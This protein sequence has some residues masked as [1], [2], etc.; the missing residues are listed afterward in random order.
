M[1]DTKTWKR[2]GGA[3]GLV[4]G[5]L[6]AGG[7]LAGTVT[8]GAAEDTSGGTDSSTSAEDP[9]PGRGDEEAL[10]GDVR[11]QVEA[12]VLAAYPDADIERS[13]TDSG[14]V[15]ESHVVTADGERLT[16]LVGEDFAVTGTETGGPG[17]GGRGGPGEC[18]DDGAA[19]D[20][21]TEAP[22]EEGTTTN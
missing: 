2:Y 7:V 14:G 15:Y 10:T 6:V 11:T 9:R 8:A 13:E 21:S 4:A 12:A 16:V 1:S 22:A 18:E 3:L 19:T 17:R 20:Q 5:G